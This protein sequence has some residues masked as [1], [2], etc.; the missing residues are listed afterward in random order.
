MMNLLAA[1]FRFEWYRLLR[2]RIM[3]GSLAAFVIIAGLAIRTG[4]QAV[5]VRLVQLDSIRTAYQRD[6]ESQWK[7][8]TDTSAAGRKKA[9]VAGL[10]AVVNYRL[11]QNALW[12]PQPLQTLSTGISDIQPFYHQVQTTVNFT[13]PPNI[14]VSN[15]VRL[16]A[17]NFDLAFVWLYILPLLVIAFCYPLYAEEKESGTAALLTVQGSSLRRIIGYKWLFRTTLISVLVLLLNVAGFVAAPLHGNGI[18]LWGWC[19]VTQLYILLWASLAW[20]A[21]SLRYNSALTALL[22]TGCWLLAVMIGPAVA[23]I[24][25]AARHPLPLRSELASLQRHESEEIWSMP[26]RA[27]IDSFNVAHPQYMS[28]FNPA[29]DTGRP[30]MRFVAGYYYLLEKRVKQAAATMDKEKMVRNHYFERMSAINPVLH[31]QQLYN[32]LAGTSLDDY[33]DYRQQ[34]AAF[35]RQWKG[36]IY[37]YQLAEKPLDAAAFRQF[38]VFALHRQSLSAGALLSDCTLLYVLIVLFAAGGYFLFYRNAQL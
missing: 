16:F 10:G 24:Y 3:L 34:V 22:L 36:F 12:V 38:P 9:A 25:L 28:S 18:S 27:L 32:R 21:V 5:Q 31:T 19:W 6:F 26:G 37:A 11:P 2:S 30:G 23:N 4:R 1:L 14:P 17:G 15:P 29:R 8:M 7:L 35:Q 33:N 13:E 20:L